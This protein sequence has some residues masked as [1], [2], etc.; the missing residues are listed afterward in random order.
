MVLF[1]VTAP[2]RNSEDIDNCIELLVKKNADNVFSVTP[3]NRNP[4]FNMVEV[5]KDGKVR[6]VKKGD[7]GTRQSAPEVF[8]MNASIYVWWKDILK[9]KRATILENSNIYIMPKERSVDI[10][11]AIDF[12]IAEMLLKEAEGN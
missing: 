12:K 1:H 3:A 8:D 9:E 5:S 2:L 11:D 4:Y 6:L 7:F 10:D